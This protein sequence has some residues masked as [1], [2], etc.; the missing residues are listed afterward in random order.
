MR[1]HSMGERKDGNN[2]NVPWWMVQMFFKCT[3][4]NST[5]WCTRRN[6]PQNIWATTKGCPHQCSVTPT[7]SETRHY[8]MLHATYYKILERRRK[9]VHW[10]WVTPHSVKLNAVACYT[11]LTTKHQSNYGRSCHPQRGQCAMFMATSA[12]EPVLRVDLSYISHKAWVCRDLFLAD[13]SSWNSLR[14]GN[15]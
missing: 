11:R 6:L 10:G 1:I 15:F 3:R 13:T 7:L 5:L 2:S 4:W 8:N 12:L 14:I 9:V